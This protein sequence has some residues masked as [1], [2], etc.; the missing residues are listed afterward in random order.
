MSTP[1]AR[2]IGALAICV[3]LASCGFPPGL[4]IRDDYMGRG[5]LDRLTGRDRVVDHDGMGNTILYP[6]PRQAPKP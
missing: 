3:L 1:V 5:L 2:I 4:K 6:S